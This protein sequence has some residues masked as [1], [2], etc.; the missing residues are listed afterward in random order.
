MF[1]PASVQVFGGLLPRS[2]GRKS[3]NEADDF[4]LGVGG[5]TEV[6]GEEFVG[7]MVIV[8]C[9]WGFGGPAEVDKDINGGP[10]RTD[11]VLPSGPGVSGGDFTQHDAPSRADFVAVGL[12]EGSP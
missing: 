1:K 7:I 5:V 3:F 11:G 9:A 2:F 8:P 6:G 4:E 12:V 10:N